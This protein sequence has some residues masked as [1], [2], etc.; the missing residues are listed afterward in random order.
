MHMTYLVSNPMRSLEKEYV[1]RL[2]CLSLISNGCLLFTDLMIVFTR[3]LL[4]SDQKL[5]T[6]IAFHARI[7]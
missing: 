5:Q 4:G 2:I 1:Q 7:M 3:T 6:Y